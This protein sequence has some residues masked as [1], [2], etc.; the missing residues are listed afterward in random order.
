M[1][2]SLK[3]TIIWALTATFAVA[4][5]R[6]LEP[7]QT[8]L[9]FSFQRQ[10]GGLLSLLSLPNLK[11]PKVTGMAIYTDWGILRPDR[12]ELVG[13]QN[14]R[15]PMVRE[16]SVN[17]E[18]VVVVEGKL[19][20]RQGQPCGLRYRVVHLLSA[21][22]L[23]AEI[24]L[25]AESDFQSMRGFLAAMFSF[26]E[27]PEWFARTEKGWL[28]AETKHEG[29]VF[30]SAHNPLNKNKPILG[31]ANSETGWALVLTLKEAKPDD[32][33]NVLIHA[34]P[35]GSGGV[36]FAWCDGIATKE[37]NAGEEWRIS[38]KLGFVR[39]DEFFETME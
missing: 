37:M 27:A 19:K 16:Q 15:E 28:F 23:T 24:S 8:H 10:F 39:L 6:E 35:K 17:G 13:S 11:A 5:S 7:V 30:Q 20:D 21:N 12:Y 2:R 4:V 32:I 22:E 36:F 31:V 38:V 1:K 14:E 29:R 26:S 3:L 25:L 18:R 33:D 9:L 34:N